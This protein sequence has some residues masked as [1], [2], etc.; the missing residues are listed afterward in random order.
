MSDVQK[1]NDDKID[2]IENGELITA[3]KIILSPLPGIGDYF[4]MLSLVYEYVKRQLENGI[5]VYFTEGE[6]NNSVVLLL[7]NFSQVKKSV[8]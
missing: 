6:K 4:M 1:R 2:I 7:N 5:E 8:F 3:K